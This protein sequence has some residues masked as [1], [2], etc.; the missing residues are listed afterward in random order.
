M[1][2]FSR[3]LRKLLSGLPVDD[4]RLQEIRLRVHAPILLRF[5]DGERSVSEEGRLISSVAEGYRVTPGDLKETLDYLSGYSLYAYEEELRQGFLTIQG[6]HRIGLAGKAVVEAGALRGMK[7]ITFMNVRLAREIRGCADGLLPFVYEKGKLC[8]TLIL[9]PPG[10]GKTTLLRDLIRQISDGNGQHPGMT[11]GV[12]D[13]RSEIGACYQGI[14]Q[15]DL[16][17]RTDVLDGS[18]K[19]QGMLMLIRTMSP[20]TVAVDEIGGRADVEALEYS[21]NCGCKILATVH[22]SSMEELKKKAAFERILRERW[23]ERYI[24]LR[25]RRSPGMVKTVCDEAG[26]ILYEQDEVRKA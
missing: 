21:M 13:E 9:S 11:V 26:R 25:G 16:G 7:Y 12:V 8:H 2:I 22:G 17:I 19:A 5:Q 4:G 15:N 20:E 10:A 1:K 3:R 23:F 24:I 14:P 6:G 18:P